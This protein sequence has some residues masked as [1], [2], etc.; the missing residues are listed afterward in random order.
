MQEAST[1]ALET[2]H[3]AQY[4]TSCQITLLT[5]GFLHKFGFIFTHGTVR[6]LVC[7]HPPDPEITPHRSR[8]VSQGRNQIIVPT[9]THLV[10][11]VLT[12]W[13]PETGSDRLMHPLSSVCTCQHLCKWWHNPRFSLTVSPENC[14]LACHVA[15][16]LLLV[17]LSALR[18]QAPQTSVL[19]EITCTETGI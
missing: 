2:I 18:A 16:T 4:G 9:I 17:G 19:N 15:Q 14:P 3:T 6:Y 1:D 5:V 11:C 8:S 7:K 12:D 10:C 13:L